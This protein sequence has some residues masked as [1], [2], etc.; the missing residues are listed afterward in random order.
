MPG[1]SAGVTLVLVAGLVGLF[2]LLAVALGNIGHLART[3]AAAG[4]SAARARLAAESGLAYAAARLPRD[5][6]PR[7]GDT[8]E[9]RSD[10]WACRDPEET[11]PE[12]LRNPS[13]ARGEPWR[14][15]VALGADGAD[16]DADGAIDEA[17]EGGG[18][19]T[20]GEPWQDLDG[21][22]AFTAA[23]GR[24]RGGERPF[25]H[26]FVLRVRAPGA[27]LP[28]NNGR[29]APPDHDSIANPF[30]R[31]LAHALNNLGAVLLPVNP[32]VGRIDVPAG[33]DG[34]PVRISR[35]GEHLLMRRPPGGYRSLA[36]L[37]EALTGVT[38]AY[39]A[40][41]CGRLLPFLDIGPGEILDGSAP[42]EEDP[43][44]DFRYAPV[45]LAAAPRE[46]LESLWRYLSAP[47]SGWL[48]DHTGLHGVPYG[49]PGVRAGGLQ[50]HKVKKIMIFPDEAAALATLAAQ[51]RDGPSPGSWLAFRKKLAADA[52]AAFP[53]DAGILSAAGAAGPGGD[54]VRAKADL[55]FLSVSLDRPPHATLGCWGTWGIDHGSAPVPPEPRPFLGI[56]ISACLMRV[57]YPDFGGT[58]PYGDP[59]LPYIVPPAAYTGVY[60]ST[61]VR[62]QGM[63]LAPPTRFSVESF[64][65]ARVTDR[66][67]ARAAAR[68]TL[69]AAERLD[70][71]AQEDFEN[72]DGS[73]LLLS[74]RG[75]RAV[76]EGTRTAH[77]DPPGGTCP[78]LASLPSFNFRGLPP[79]PACRFCRD[80]GAIVLAGRA[81]G[82][83][84]ALQ[85]WA[86][87]EDAVATVPESELSSSFL[88]PATASFH[89]DTIDIP[90]CNAWEFTIPE[91]PDSFILEC[92]GIAPP[93]IE[94][95]SVEF[96]CRPAQAPLVLAADFGGD[97][98]GVLRVETTPAWR[99]AEGY[100]TLFTVVR[101]K[102]LTS[103]PLDF[104]GI[105]AER[106][107]PASDLTG[108]RA[109]QDHVVLTLS[110]DGSST[111]C[112][113]WING[114]PSASPPAPSVLEAPP[115]GVQLA[116][117]GIDELRFYD[118]VLEAP[119]VE[120]RHLLGRHVLPSPSRRALY[121]SPR[122]ELGGPASL[123]RANWTGIPSGEAP[124][125]ERVRI[126]VRLHAY[127]AAGTELAGSP[128][129][130][131]ASGETTGLS[132]TGR[133]AAFDYEVEF[134]NVTPDDSAPLYKA[135]IFESLWIAL[136]RA[137]VS[138]VWSSWGQD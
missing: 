134:V 109:G 114:K 83:Q 66:E 123:D 23:S 1:R 30:H 69:R 85:Y 99:A 62:P 90:S 94:A 87:T 112:T 2:L 22:G 117:E 40:W 138:P 102:W 45:E 17:G 24:L 3:S 48:A 11:P 41:E 61:L 119:E 98:R 133:A 13:F 5:P 4:L 89:F 21:D 107:V 127:D 37:R 18:L 137:R 52:P 108:S 55:A 103:P 118:R 80:I 27:L 120:S 128:V 68:G 135:P 44:P 9:S 14:E 86:F 116:V 67:A 131:G 106:F 130:L 76:G 46:V 47:V 26:L 88:P 63:T 136:R 126:E 70:F 60:G 7:R 54:W 12:S 35:L 20:P 82:N 10:S 59:T 101:D 125:S 28:V 53:V 33:P 100:G 97:V 132:L 34:E 57:P 77:V 93:F 71:F 50:L 15:T 110:G 115:A 121:R 75:I 56:D 96:W 78:W 32:A 129:L 84:T 64:G 16:N 124:G 25:A 29:M 105:L 72:H 122:Y 31:G 65:R 38:P 8:M 91:S 95:M 74:R 92:P 113:L 111:L 36:A 43:G 51:F 6:W 49:S 58:W 73:P 42:V 104:T 19:W 39:T 81:C 79:S